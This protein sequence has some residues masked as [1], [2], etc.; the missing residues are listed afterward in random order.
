MARLRFI[1]CKRVFACS[2]LCRAWPRHA[3][4]PAPAVG[5]A[6]TLST[7]FSSVCGSQA[8]VGGAVR[9]AGGREQQNKLGG[10][11]TSDVELVGGGDGRYGRAYSIRRRP[12]PAPT[13]SSRPDK[14]RGT[15]PVTISH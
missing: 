14:L 3:Q 9:T 6:V 5:G 7:Q 4:L 2:A 13:H 11:R 15:Q 12:R 1:G 10:I 8:A